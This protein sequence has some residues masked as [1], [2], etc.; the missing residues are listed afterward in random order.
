[1]VPVRR[2]EGLR[3]SQHVHDAWLLTQRH[4]H[5]CQL[6]PE[7]DGKRLVRSIVRQ[8]AERVE[9]LLEESHR[10]AASARPEP[11]L[12]RVPHCLLPL[13]ACTA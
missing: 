1:M 12:A 8:M 4:E 10:V 3:L 11:R 6:R 13:S 9:R 7:I 5:A 2:G